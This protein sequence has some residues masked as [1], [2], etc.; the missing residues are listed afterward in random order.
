SPSSID[1]TIRSQIPGA[2]LYVL[3]PSGVILGPNASLDVSGSFHI[4]TAD[5]LRLGDGADGAQFHANLSRHSVLSVAPPAAFGFLSPHPAAIAI[6][7]SGLAVPAGQT[8]S[9]IGGDI[10]FVGDPTL[11]FLQAPG[12]RIH[13]ASVASPGEVTLDAPHLGTDAFARLG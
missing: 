11:G 9:F 6:Q 3:N 12:G 4:S 7:R 8:L 1:G 13:L 10:D 2:H 5:Y